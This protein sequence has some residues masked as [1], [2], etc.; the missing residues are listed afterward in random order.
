MK[1]KQLVKSLDPIPQALKCCIQQKVPH[2]TGIQTNTFYRLINI[3]GMF[4]E[5]RERLLWEQMG[6]IDTL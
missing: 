6:Y 4:S 1:R 3:S 2:R 5:A